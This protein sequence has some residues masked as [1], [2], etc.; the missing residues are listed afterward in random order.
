[1]NRAASRPDPLSRPAIAFGSLVALAIAAAAFGP[2]ATLPQAWQEG[3][4]AETMAVNFLDEPD[5]AVIVIDGETGA[6]IA[7]LGV[8]EG[9][10]VRSTMRGLARERTRRDIGREPAFR[11]QRQTSGAL[12]LND[13]QTGKTIRLDAFGQANAAAFA[14]FLDHRRER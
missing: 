13:P 8:G 9:G 1:M 10:F 12:V 14:A 11:L 4:P 5:G 7:R 3:T 2:K 6:T